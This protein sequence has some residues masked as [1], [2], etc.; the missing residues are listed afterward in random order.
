MHRAALVFILVLIVNLTHARSDS[1]S[2][3]IGWSFNTGLSWSIGPNSTQSFF[4]P[5][6]G[7]MIYDQFKLNQRF[8]L[9]FGIGTHL[10]SVSSDHFFTN[11]S[12]GSTEW[13]ELSLGRY[14]HLD[15]LIIQCPLTIKRAFYRERKEWFLEIEGGII[16]GLTLVSLSYQVFSGRQSIRNPQRFRPA[17]LFNVSFNKWDERGGI[18]TKLGLLSFIYLNKSLPERAPLVPVQV[19]IGGYIG[20]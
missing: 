11:R 9:V 4:N 8:F 17:L 7:I 14:A 2:H 13:T 18:T 19:S 1:T 5:H 12:D 10:H 3:T 20:F 16:P 6:T 15:N